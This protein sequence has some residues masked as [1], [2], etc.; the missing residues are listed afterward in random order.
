MP[1][2]IISVCFPTAGKSVLNFQINMD[3]RGDFDGMEK[4]EFKEL[5][6]SRKLLENKLYRFHF[7]RLYFF[8]VFGAKIHFFDQH[9]VAQISPHN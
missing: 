5:L 4:S 7:W 6:I 2:H 9:F 3:L 1:D 8:E